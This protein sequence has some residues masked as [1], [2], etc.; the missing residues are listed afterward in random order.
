MRL[1]WVS[2]HDLTNEN[3]K[4]L[5]KA[6]GKVEVFQYKETVKD[7]KELKEFADRHDANGYI[8]VLPPHFIM[9]L[10]KIDNR[11]IYRFV[12]NRII[13]GNEVEYIPI[14][15]ERVIEIHVVTER[16]V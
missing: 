7:V 6:F 1:V 4:I 16:I 15:L 8:V 11:P 2:R 3:W 13:I 9:D 5:E 10:M 14:G 12:V